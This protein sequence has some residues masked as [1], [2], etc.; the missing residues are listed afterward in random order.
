MFISERRRSWTWRHKKPAA[1][2]VRIKGVCRMRGP[3]VLWSDKCRFVSARRDLRG[4]DPQGRTPGDLHVEQ[5]TKFELVI[6]SRRPRRSALD[7]P[8]CGGEGDAV[9]NSSNQK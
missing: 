1:G 8:Q 9:I 5:P 7:D 4:Q 6:T 2:S 3:Y